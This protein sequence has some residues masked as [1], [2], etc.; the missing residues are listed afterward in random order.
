MGETSCKE[1]KNCSSIFNILM[2]KIHLI[3]TDLVRQGIKNIEDLRFG[4]EERHIN[5]NRCCY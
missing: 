1:N 2:E 5:Y 3:Q 4:E